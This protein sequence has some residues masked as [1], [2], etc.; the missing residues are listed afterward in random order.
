MDSACDSFSRARNR[1]MEKPSRLGYEDQ[2]DATAFA[3]VEREEARRVAR[4][5]DELSEG[6]PV[7]TSRAA[8]QRQ[9]HD[10]VATKDASPAA[11]AAPTASREAA[12]GDKGS[13][14][15]GH[16]LFAVWEETPTTGLADFLDAAS[17]KA[18]DDHTTL[19]VRYHLPTERIDPMI[20]WVERKW[21]YGPVSPP[22]WV[23][24]GTGIQPSAVM[25]AMWYGLRCD[26]V[27]R[28]I[29]KDDPIPSDG[30]VITILD[31]ASPSADTH[32]A[33]SSHPD[34][35][36]S[37][38]HPD[39]VTSGKGECCK[40]ARHGGGTARS[41]EEVRIRFVVSTSGPVPR[42]SDLEADEAPFDYKHTSSRYPC[43]PYYVMRSV[44]AGTYHAHREGA[45]GN[46][47]AKKN[48]VLCGTSSAGKTTVAKM[49]EGIG[50]NVVY[51]DD[52]DARELVEPCEAMGIGREIK[53]RLHEFGAVDKI[54]L[55]AMSD[56][57]REDARRF[58]AASSRDD[59]S[60]HGAASHDDTTQEAALRRRGVIYDTIGNGPP[61]F[62]KDEDCYVI[63]VYAPFEDM[64]RNFL[65]RLTTSDS[66][67]AGVL[68][69]FGCSFRA[70]SST[71]GASGASGTSTAIDTINRR[72][73]LGMMKQLAAFYESENALTRYINNLFHK[74]G[75]DDDNDHRIEPALERFTVDATVS[76]RG[77][78]P[79]QVYEEVKKLVDAHFAS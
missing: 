61:I 17:K 38:S 46:E 13:E 39:D 77:K 79:I 5:L 52:H 12:N 31:N 32:S 36:T 44:G 74:M 26:G 45:K 7:P 76:T 51:R 30:K 60:P 67:M 70:V 23:F 59:T 50:Y 73:V 75:I 54:A 68:W 69:I 62:E 4:A 25:E 49:L 41:G 47:A 78:T 1:G 8:R 72:A 58:F 35:A 20:Q 33:S 22:L 15:R 53:A 48:V 14:A 19:Y 9:R 56:A 71:S 34:G 28:I 10:A 65:T 2:W 55:K 6:R 64:V 21:A 43:K 3:N 27:T 63:L 40:R 66:R 57:M 24:I 37:P 29:G 16:R 42:T 11:T 18:R